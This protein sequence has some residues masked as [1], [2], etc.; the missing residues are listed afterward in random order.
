MKKNQDISILSVSF[1][2]G[3]ATLLTA[4]IPN[5]TLY[6]EDYSLGMIESL[7]TVP[8]V[9]AMIT[10]I[11]NNY[12]S[13][14]LGIKRVLE[15]GILIA[16]VAGTLPLFVDYLPIIY[17]S[18]F[19][20][21]LGIGLYS[22]HA[23]SLIALFYT[24]QKKSTFLGLQVGI[25]AAGNALFL[26]L[27]SLIVRYQWQLI[28]GLYFLL[29]PV[30]LMIIKFVPSI[31]NLKESKDRTKKTLSK[32][33]L[34]YLFL[35]LVTFI[36]I[37]GVQLKIPT[38][39]TELSN[40]NTAI[41]GTVL[42]IMNLAGLFAGIAFGQL[43]KKISNWVFVL[44][45]TGAALMVFVMTFSNVVW[46][47]I[48]S[49]ILFNFVYSFTGPFIV[50]KLNSLADSSQVVTVNSMFT[51]IIIG[52]QFIAPIIWNTLGSIVNGATKEILMI[53]AFT[54]VILSIFTTYLTVK[55][56]ST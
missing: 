38:L 9:G 8:S 1:I 5:L 20:L 40:G 56:K 36:I 13:K 30:L 52:S 33:I 48:V 17:A 19:V 32:N 10:I 25:T 54:L 47:S 16:I 4:A 6:F 7:V 41:G 37:Y 39:F 27:A 29:V 43:I 15:I 50:L 44:G 24:A 31:E 45:Y 53:I 14:K 55:T 26:L 21:G 3:V 51:L 11:L 22:P 34:F 12:F 49:A 35:C 46:L 28:Y 42:S 23:I 18:R 2:T